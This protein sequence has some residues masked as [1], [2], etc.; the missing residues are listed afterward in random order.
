M[1]LPRVRFTLSR[2]MV[3]VAVVAIVLGGEIAIVEW[4]NPVGV[5]YQRTGTIYYFDRPPML[6]MIA[7]ATL[8]GF[9]A[10]FCPSPAGPNQP[11]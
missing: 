11:K 7:C 1:R 3:A 5:I 4:S 2:L 6:A 9:F 8:F 10:M